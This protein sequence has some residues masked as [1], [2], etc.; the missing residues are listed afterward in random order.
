MIFPPCQLQVPAVRKVG[1]HL[2]LQ[3]TVALFFFF[4][5]HL[6]VVL[7]NMPVVKKNSMH[8][9]LSLV[10][11]RPKDGQLFFRSQYT[12]SY[13]KMRIERWSN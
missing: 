2:E 5:P 4:F 11:S 12:D 8:S 13:D 9:Y 7:C 3:L 10:C 1:V 6:T